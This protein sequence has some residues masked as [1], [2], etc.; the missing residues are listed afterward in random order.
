MFSNVP[1]DIPP[2]QHQRWMERELIRKRAWNAQQLVYYVQM[3]AKAQRAADS[4]KLA[5]QE[6]SAPDSGSWNAST[7]AAHPNSWPPSPAAMNLSSKRHTEFSHLSNGGYHEYYRPGDD[8]LE[9]I[10]R[11]RDFWG[12]PMVTGPIPADWPWPL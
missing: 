1:D 4:S 9:H 12:G 11:V 5:S 3:G 6:T 8:L 7:A 2:E 10:E